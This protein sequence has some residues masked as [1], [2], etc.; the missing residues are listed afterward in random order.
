M[1]TLLKLDGFYALVLVLGLFLF[2]AC[3]TT[4]PVQADPVSG[5]YNTYP[6]N[7]TSTVDNEI[8][9]APGS[10]YCV[11][12]VCL[13]IDATVAESGKYL[14]VREDSATGTKISQLLLTTL[15]AYRDM[16]WGENGY[17]LS[18]NKAL[19]FDTT[20]T[21]TGEAR[22]TGTYQIRKVR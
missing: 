22:V 21:G 6:F 1:K 20:G 19:Y 2:W 9:A 12:L 5:N 7:V 18:E 16:Y 11:D 3:A 14:Y 4:P 15:G 8:I 10:G 17:T 13:T